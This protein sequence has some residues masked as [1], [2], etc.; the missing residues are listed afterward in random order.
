MPVRALPGEFIYLVRNDG[1]VCFEVVNYFW[2]SR[3]VVPYL[4]CSCVSE[5]IFILNTILCVDRLT[6][7]SA[8]NPRS[9]SWSRG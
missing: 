8:D 5:I 9:E 1:L 2:P 6:R 7:R 3:R 4:C